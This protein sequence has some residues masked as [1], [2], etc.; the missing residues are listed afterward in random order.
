MKEKEGKIESKRKRKYKK[1]INKEIINI[2]SIGR[3]KDRMK[4]R[5]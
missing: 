1:T 5:K 3:R 4:C 2:G